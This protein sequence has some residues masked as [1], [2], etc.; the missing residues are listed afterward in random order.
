MLTRQKIILR[1]LDQLGGTAGHTV[2]VKLAFLL[3]HETPLRD[4]HTFYD[5][6]PYRYGPFSFALY[7]ELQG[8][9]RDGYVKGGEDALSLQGATRH[10]AREKADELSWPD[11]CAVK[12][13]VFTYGRM[14]TSTLL[15]DVYARYPWFASRSELMDLVPVD[16]P[17]A[18]KPNVAVY[19]VGYEG[20]SV[21]GFF[22]RLLHSGM[23][24]ILD[25][26]AN[27]VSRKYGF[28]KRS[29]SETA[30]KLGLEYCHLPDLGI[31]GEQRGDLGD[32]DSYQRLLDHYEN[33]M[34]PR[35]TAEIDRLI[36]LL[37]QR[38]SVLLCV[39]KDVRQCHRGRL[40]RVAGERSGLSVKHL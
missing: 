33:E 35:Q 14:G 5:F 16:L 8:L 30:G 34:L 11:Q 12:N 36:G 3:R 13:I 20:R 40:A 4:D 7:R 9:E 6:V 21:D 39:E 25:V 17:P 15:K 22:D 23:Q 18:T 32:I 24:A 28:A 2:L 31:P 10:L 29:L 26:R 37:R 27:P 19:T 1:L 38:P